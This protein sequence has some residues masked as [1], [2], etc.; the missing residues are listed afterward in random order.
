MSD[1]NGNVDWRETALII[2]HHARSILLSPHPPATTV[3]E[4]FYLE[5]LVEALLDLKLATMAYDVEGVYR[6]IKEIVTLM[7]ELRRLWSTEG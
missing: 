3:E 6:H 4:E 5:E 1:G 7:V 2:Y